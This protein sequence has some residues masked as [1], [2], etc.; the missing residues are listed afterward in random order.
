MT[1]QTYNGWTNYATWRVGLELVN[2]NYEYYHETMMNSDTKIDTHE[3]SQII[4]D[5]VYHFLTDEVSDRSV[6]FSYAEAFLSDVN[7]YELAEHMMLDLMED[8]KEVENVG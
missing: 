2:D 6:V 1:D 5:D 4:K 8:L 3:L 7:W